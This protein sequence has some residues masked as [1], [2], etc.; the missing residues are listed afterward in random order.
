MN[1]QIVGA[2]VVGQA[3]GKG[4]ARLGHEIQF[5]DKDRGV[6][7][8]LRSE[9][10]VLTEPSFLHGLHNTVDLYFVCTPEQVVEGVIDSMVED[11]R[12]YTTAPCPSEPI[13]IRSSVP[14]RTA[15][16]IMKRYGELHICSNPEFLREAVAEYEFL[17]PPGVIIGECC[18]EH[19]DLLEE[20]Y[21][22]FRKPIC[23]TTPEVAELT[24]LAVNGYLACQ[25]S[26]WNQIKLLANELGVNSH[27][28]GMLASY[29]DDR[30]SVYGSRMHGRPYRGKCLPK[31]LQ[32]LINLAQRKSIN[33]QLLEA[34][35]GIN[36]YYLVKGGE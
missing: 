10:E 17:N 23:R 11:W 36:D 20:L 12:K 15:R 4:F 18:K 29:G 21:K 14:P 30:I 7:D 5:V 13:V 28:V 2:G 3:T 8:L 16:G 26:Y 22:P 32:Q 1:I 33:G 35:K 34:V 27:E 25:I 9:F 24:K 19:G 6:L 31:D